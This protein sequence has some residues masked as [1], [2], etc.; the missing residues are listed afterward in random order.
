MNDISCGISIWAQVSFVLSQSMRLT[1]EQ[2][3]RG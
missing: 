1:N 2:F 3:A